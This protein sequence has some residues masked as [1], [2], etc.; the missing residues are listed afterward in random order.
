[1]R[2]GL[3]V[4]AA[5]R[6]DGGARQG[7]LARRRTLLAAAA[8]RGLPHAPCLA[9]AAARASRPTPRRRPATRARRL[10]PARGLPQGLH[11]RDARLADRADARRL[12][13]GDHERRRARGHRPAGRGS[14]LARRGTRDRRPREPRGAR[15]VRADA[16][17]LAPE[18]PAPADRACAVRGYGGPFPATPL[19]A[20]PP[21][22]SSATHP[23]TAIWPSASGRSSSP[24]RTHFRT[25]VESGALVANGSDAPIEELDP[26]AGVCAGSSVRSTIA[27]RGDPSRLSPSSRPCT[28]R[29]SRRRG[30]RAT[31]EDAASSCPGTS[32]TSS[33]STGIRWLAIRQS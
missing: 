10:V 17:A 23:R 9:V 1:M 22:S 33:C 27:P 30:S 29:S 3:R 24:A 2:E 25:L 6:C 4:V 11:G 13:R 26:G 32:P 20:S 31:S 5:P 8:R 12:G 28:R 18:G 15:R 14:R 16:G 21:R 7:R 19:S